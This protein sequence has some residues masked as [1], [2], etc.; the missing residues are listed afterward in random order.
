MAV[1]RVDV[2][3]R[4]AAY[5]D[6]HGSALHLAVVLVGADPANAL[7]VRNKGRLIEKRSLLF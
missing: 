4:V 3:V 2:A 7:Y 5:R 6:R 1:V